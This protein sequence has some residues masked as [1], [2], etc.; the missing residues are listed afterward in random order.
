[1][2]ILANILYI[3]RALPI[4]IPPSFFD[5]IK[6]ILNNFLWQGKKKR[7]PYTTLTKHKSVGGMG[8]PGLHDY[9]VAVLLDQLKYWFTLSPDKQ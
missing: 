5:E 2:L 9:Y 3:Y 7:C 8:L 1:M 4:P 6:C